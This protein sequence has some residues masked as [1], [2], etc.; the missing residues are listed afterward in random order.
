LKQTN[1]Q[2]LLVEFC[3]IL[4]SV[5]SRTYP[6]VPKKPVSRS[7]ARYDEAQEN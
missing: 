5:R 2:A 6:Y 3:A 7:W 4:S 1:R